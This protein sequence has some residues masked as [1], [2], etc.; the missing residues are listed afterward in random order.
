M[1][2]E[3]VQYSTNGVAVGSYDYPMLANEALV[4]SASTATVSNDVL[5]VTVKPIVDRMR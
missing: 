2:Y 3:V 5:T 4:V 1:V